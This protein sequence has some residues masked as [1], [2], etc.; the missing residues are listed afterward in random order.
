M[1]QTQE[2]DPDAERNVPYVESQ[3]IMT[4]VQVVA[5]FALTYALFLTFHGAS[6]PGGGF[7]GGAIAGS[8]VL[9]IA[10]AFG[11]GPTRDW[12]QNKVV[13]GLAAG[14]TAVFVLVGAL[15]IAFGGAFLEYGVYGE[16]LPIFDGYTDAISWGMEAV[17]IGGIALIVSGVVM[18]LFFATAAGY[19]PGDRR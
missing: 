6:T 18:G 4:T 14:G 15:P 10:F 13:V 7:Q 3:V 17:E 2:Y 19:Q 1:S 16:I 11:I 5:P 12:L 8:V 9:M